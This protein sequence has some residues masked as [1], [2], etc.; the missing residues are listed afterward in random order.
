MSAAARQREPPLQ[1]RDLGKSFDGADD[2]P[3]EVIRAISLTLAAGEIVSIVGPSGCGKTTLL[4]SI[5]GLIPRTRGQVLWHGQ[6]LP[7][8]PPRLGYML[9]KDLLLPWR[10]AASNVKL[11]LQVKRTP[12]D[13]RD[14]RARALLAQLGL[15]EFADHFPSTLSGGMRQRVALARTLATD[16]DV[17][18]L[19]E[20]FSALDFQTKI[21]LERDTARLIRGQGR[22]LL[23]ITHDV[24][25]A[26][27]LSDRV[28]VLS[29]RPCTVVAEH[30]IDLPGDRT[31]M[32]ALRESRAF[33]AWCGRFGRSST[34]AAD[35]PAA[36]VLQAPA[37]PG[38]RRRTA[39]RQTVRIVV[40][41]AAV[42][43]V[44]LA[45][46]EW[47]TH[48]GHASAFLYGSPS[49]IGI[50][51]LA[52]ARD[53]S[54]WND[55]VTTGAETLAGFAL[56]N[57]IGTALG[58]SLW[59]SRFLSRVVQPFLLGLGSIPIVAL[60]PIA[61]IWFG[62]GFA[63]KVAMATLSVVVV[64]LTVAYK[65]AVGVDPD[66][67]NLLRSLGATRHQI[68][69]HLILP[70]SLTDIFAG[71]KLTVGFALVGAIVGEFM[72]SSSGL[73]HAIF[74]AGSLYAIAKVL[75]EL[76][77]TAALAIALSAVVIRAERA[78]LPWRHD[79]Q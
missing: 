58:L 20:P 39:W 27:G 44:L 35:M 14:A 25:E 79:L 8:V 71:F 10:T 75:A 9:Q 45:A 6:V 28:I 17:L 5:C 64:S 47:M 74:K 78:L 62:T 49:A 60:A 30:C 36:A 40:V 32:I 13:G 31:D 7:G 73:G 61:I 23:L 1:V 4:N 52:A 29:S 48:T 68:F 2:Q 67:V 53:G 65:G 18:L 16:P 66:Q 41:Q 69:R 59:Y 37:R 76:A 55:A 24:E 34:L 43:A 26:V 70:A 50:D 63:S 57:L 3:I 12:R 33:A 42:I 56:G 46:W 22:S 72:S 15:A 77:V 19:D 21:L 51:L 11:G 54:L 38:G